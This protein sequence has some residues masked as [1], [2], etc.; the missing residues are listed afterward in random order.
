ML[1]KYE[2]F[3]GYGVVFA[4]VLTAAFGL[5]TLKTH[6]E[7]AAPATGALVVGYVD[8]TAIDKDFPDI[9]TA[10]KTLKSLE[11]EVNVA[12]AEFNSKVKQLQ[13][14]IQREY[15]D[16]TKGLTDA[17]K[18]KY[19]P[20]YEEMFNAQVGVLKADFEKRKTEIQA[21]A[22]D[23][24][25]VAYDKVRAT[26]TTVAQEQGVGLVLNKNIIW[27]GGKDLTPDVLKKAGVKK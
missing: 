17:D 13:N 2:R 22:Q 3:L 10:K 26:I 12:N 15:E 4:I 6:A 24:W 16:K 19:A 27:Y 7:P 8:D 20:V 14:Q 21:K 5:F 1:K 11:D 9:L 18:Q 23:I 25:K